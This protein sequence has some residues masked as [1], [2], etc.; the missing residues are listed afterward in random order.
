MT[1]ESST[2]IRAFLTYFDTFF[3]TA[4]GQMCDSVDLAILPEGLNEVE[5]VSPG[6]VSFT[7]GPRGKETHWRQVAFLLHSP[8][9]VQKGK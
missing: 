1:A 6:V 4:P 8:I 2:T 7:T 5:P 3:A 9:K